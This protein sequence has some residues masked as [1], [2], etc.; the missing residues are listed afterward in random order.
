M[1]D[2][3]PK[4]NRNVRRIS[5]VHNLVKVKKEKK[6]MMRKQEK[7]KSM[8]MSLPSFPLPSFFLLF[9]NRSIVNMEEMDDVD[10][11]MS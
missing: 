3:P 8:K 1:P 11:N 10:R 9:L 4:S 5:L 7:L 2:K 6:K